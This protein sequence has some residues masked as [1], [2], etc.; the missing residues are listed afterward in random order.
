MEKHKSIRN[1]VFLFLAC[2]VQIVLI[3][4]GLLSLL[5]PDIGSLSGLLQIFLHGTI[6]AFLFFRFCLAAN[7]LHAHT[8]E[9]YRIFYETRR[10]SARLAWM[11]S[12]WTTFQLLDLL[13]IFFG[14]LASIGQSGG[15]TNF[16]LPKGLG[17]MVVIVFGIFMGS[18]PVIYLGVVWWTVRTGWKARKRVVQFDKAGIKELS[19]GGGNAEEELAM[20][21]PQHGNA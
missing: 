16:G 5:P 1:A 17:Q 12:L 3:G 8:R 11:C 19:G 10:G 2:L 6:L 15:R 9:L 20:L 7:I 14:A 4:Y 13:M 21:Q 18:M